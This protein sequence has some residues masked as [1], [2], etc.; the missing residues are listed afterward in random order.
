MANILIAVNPYFDIPKIYSSDT[1][2]SYQGKSLGTM[3]PHVFAIGKLY[4][5]LCP[6]RYRF[7]RFLDCFE[8]FKGFHCMYS[9]Y[10][11]PCYTGC[12]YASVYC[13]SCTW[14]FPTPSLTPCTLLFST[15]FLLL[16]HSVSWIVPPLLWCSVYIMWFYASIWNLGITQDRRLAQFV[17]FGIL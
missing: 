5:T 12:F 17:Y 7:T 4:F 1:I 14:P 2:K 16:V 8:S 9:L 15:L 10:M 11:A 3:P 6:V 13:L